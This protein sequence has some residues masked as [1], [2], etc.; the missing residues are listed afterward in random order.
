MTQR[1]TAADTSSPPKTGS[2]GI[3]NQELCSK[4]FGQFTSIS[5]SQFGE[6]IAEIIWLHMSLAFQGSVVGARGAGEFESVLS[7]WKGQMH[8]MCLNMTLVQCCVLVQRQLWG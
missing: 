2:C 5:G 4:A 8:G 7:V 6:N 3:G 1:K